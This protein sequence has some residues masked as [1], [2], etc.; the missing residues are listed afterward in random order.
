MR[1]FHPRKW[2]FVACLFL[3]VL[4]CAFLWPRNPDW[5]ELRSYVLRSDWPRARAGLLRYVRLHPDAEEAW[6]L[7][8]QVQQKLDHPAEA[9]ECLEHLPAGSPRRAEALFR[10]GEL[11]LDQ[12]RAARAASSWLKVTEVE[13]GTGS[14]QD[15]SIWSIWAL[16]R[17]GDLYVLENRT[18]EARE[19]LWRLFHSFRPRD[20]ARIDFLFRLTVFDVQSYDPQQAVDQLEVFA[21]ADP[22]DLDVKCSLVNYYL[23]LGQVDRSRALMDQLTNKSRA[24]PRVWKTQLEYLVAIGDSAG[25]RLA[26]Q[27]SELGKKNEHSVWKF[28]GIDHEN[29]REWT[30]AIDCYRQAC[31]L[32]PRDYQTHARLAQCLRLAGRQDEFRVQID[33][34]SKNG[35]ALSELSS[36]TSKL[37]KELGTNATLEQCLDFAQMCAELGWTAEAAAWQELAE[38]RGQSRAE[39]SPSS[40]L[41]SRN[42][43]P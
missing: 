33:L 40:L 43:I 22:E 8:S 3:V 17:L 13:D 20:A 10:Q 42:P 41:G 5:N 4:L 16:G 11:Y 29:H 31:Q 27:Q 19:V 15:Q 6:F 18:E 23:G 14:T 28:R 25:L 36:Y 26:L 21:R 9:A 2:Q 7:L 37:P 24:D 32:A 30:E 35:R 39:N 34:V 1:W 12:G 38:L